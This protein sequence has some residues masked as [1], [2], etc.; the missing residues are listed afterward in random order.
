MLGFFGKIYL[1]F[2]GWADGQYLLV[3]VGLL[4]SVVSIYYYIS[5]IKMMVVKEPHEAS[6]VVKNYPAINW[7]TIGLPAL[8]TALIGCVMVTAVGGILSSPLFTW[9]SQSVAGT[10]MLQAALG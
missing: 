9:A 1:F 6:D 8:R 7:S 5:V 3:V 4:T 2:A 10:P